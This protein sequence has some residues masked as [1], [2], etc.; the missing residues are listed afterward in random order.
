MISCSR[1]LELWRNTSGE[2]FLDF[3]G[4]L[5]L[6]G[7]SGNGEVAPDVGKSAGKAYSR[8][9]AVEK[10]CASAK[11]IGKMELSRNAFVEGGLELEVGPMEGKSESGQLLE[12][13]QNHSLRKSLSDSTWQRFLLFENGNSAVIT[14]VGAHTCLHIPV[15][16]QVLS[17]VCFHIL[18]AYQQ[19]F[20]PGFLL[21]FFLMNFSML[22]KLLC[23]QD[24]VTLIKR[25]REKSQDMKDQ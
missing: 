1:A 24:F 17:C 16:V 6:P 20:K 5:Q 3:W 9:H 2:G 10:I 13:F 18:F 21:L 15:W 25:E 11:L 8:Q 7:S 14:S 22:Q 12:S 4:R 23:S 19:Q